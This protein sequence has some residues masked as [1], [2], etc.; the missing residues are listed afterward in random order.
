MRRKARARL[1]T[2]PLLETHRHTWALLD[3]ESIHEPSAERDALFLSAL[4]E[5]TRWHLDRNPAYRTFCE[6]RSFEPE[7]LQ[8][9]EDVP[10]ISAEVFKSFDL[11]TLRRV[12]YFTISSSGTGGRRTTIPLDLETVTRMLVMGESSFA[13]E[14]FLSEEPV[15]YLIF[16][17]DPAVAP[18]HG[19]AHFFTTLTEAAPSRETFFALVPEPGGHL[20]LDAETAASC[21]ARSAAAG[22]VM[23][24]IG[25]PALIARAAE[26]FSRGPIRLPKGSLVLTGGGWK[27]EA[28]AALSKEFFR[29]LLERAWGVPPD[30]VRDLYGM[31]EHAVHYI[32]CRQHRFHA[33]VY[34]R[35]RIVDPLSGAL[36]AD[37]SEG[38]LHLINPGFTTM[39]FHSLLTADIGRAAAPCPCGRATFAFEVLGRGGTSRF[40]GCAATT[41]EQVAR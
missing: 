34:A 9:P 39:P 41:L 38:V 35:V 13:E 37:G 28:R 30:R 14:G 21:L 31:T 19:N 15:T 36:T 2:P 23:R 11:T 7:R 17:P 6:R 18:G 33:P 22:R 8:R 4:R 20:R 26:G 1:S 3:L 40:R 16:A 24:V 25:L 29:E 27:G 10:S 12:D 5:N 32:E